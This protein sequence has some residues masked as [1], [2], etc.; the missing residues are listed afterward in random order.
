MAQF[1]RP[2]SDVLTTGWTTAS[3]LSSGL[4]DALDETV[5]DDADYARSSIPHGELLK[6]GLS[7]VAD[8]QSS[9]GH[10][11]RYRIGK[12]GTGPIAFTVSLRQG[13]TEIASW[14]HT[15]VDALTTYAQTLAGAE[16]DAI[17]DYAAL[18]L[19]FS[20]TTG[21]DLQLFGLLLGRT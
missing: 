21:G 14:S 10:V 15:G 3:G 16:A 8:P 12:I 20:A 13:S 5:A 4:S 2:V 18:Q 6:V 7:A 19:W 11:V 9:A 17:S 1:A